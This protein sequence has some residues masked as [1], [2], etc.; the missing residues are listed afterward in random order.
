MTAES[1]RMLGY[2]LLAGSAG[3]ALLMLV[4]LM[5]SGVQSGGAVL[6]LLLLFVLAGPLAGGGYYVLAQERT[7]RIRENQ[8]AGKRRVLDADRLFRNEL[9]ARL[10]QLAMVPGMPAQQLTRLAE[11]VGSAAQD[12][13]AW[14]DAVHLD[15][16]QSALLHRYDDLVWERVRWLGD[17]RDEPSPVL[18]EA[19]TQLQTAIDQRMDLLVRGQAPPVVAPTALLQADAP[20]AATLARV[21]L[22]DAISRDGVDYV[23]EGV[24]TH[25]TEGRTWTLLHLVPSGGDVAEH[26]L[27]VAPGGLE[28]VWLDALAGV[29]TPAV[30]QL[31]YADTLLPLVGEQSATAE[32]VTRVGATPG[33]LIRVWTYRQDPLVGIV[34][35]WPDGTLR[36]YAGRTLPARELEVWPAAIASSE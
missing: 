24:V 23:V 31:A 6:G 11:G 17:H 7:E 26:C 5:T 28:L 2:G 12:E 13:S 20:E 1:R 18:I 35:Q 14:Y 30:K 19:V 33:V 22:G 9:A 36:A 3:I 34:E 27:S 16:T 29:T 10:R 8:F 32:V 25:F 21:G 15:D 4:W